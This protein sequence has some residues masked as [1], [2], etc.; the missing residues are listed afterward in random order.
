MFHVCYPAF[1]IKKSIIFKGRKPHQTQQNSGFQSDEIIAITVKGLPGSFPCSVY[2]MQSVLFNNNVS[3]FYLP[4]R[5]LCDC[6]NDGHAR[7][8]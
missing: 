8:S 6:D 2:V 5:P 4:N 3:V 1:Q 7:Q